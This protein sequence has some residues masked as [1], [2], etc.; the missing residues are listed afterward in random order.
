MIA[1]DMQKITIINYD[2]LKKDDLL[3]LKAI[4]EIKSL[5]IHNSQ[6]NLTNSPF[7]S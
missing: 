3:F 6:I 2:R 1:V 7:K 5:N 4:E